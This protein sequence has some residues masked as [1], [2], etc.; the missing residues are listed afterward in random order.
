MITP[1]TRLLHSSPATLGE[2]R[3]ALPATVDVE[4]RLRPVT[5][6]LVA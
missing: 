3:T 6:S 4:S 1:C 2:T 5:A